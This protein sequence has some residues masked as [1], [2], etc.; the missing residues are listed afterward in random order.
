[1]GRGRGCP[2]RGRRCPMAQPSPS[3]HPLYLQIK[4]LVEKSLEDGEWR[5]GE[6]IPSETELASRYEVSQGTV[7]KAVDALAAA[8]L[9]VRRQGKGTFVATHAEEKTSTHRFLNIYDNDARDGPTTSR[10][11][12][13]RRG[14]ASAEAAR[15]L[16]IKAGDAVIVL[17]RVLEY[18]GTPVVFDEIT[19]PA[20]L[21]RGLTRARAEAHGSSMY[22]FFETEFGVRM[23]K[24]RERLR[25]VAAESEGARVL[26]VPVGQ[27]LLAVERVAYTYGERPVELRRG[28]VM[29]RRH[30]YYNELG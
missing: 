6:P 30:H 7:R 16:G 11:L 3:F 4:A 20:A 9:V 28:L 19:L 14:K 17:T 2:A 23:V 13:V 21:F 22:A 18:G 8:N 25:A 12:D 24:A 15:L 1:M 10:L 29:T 27:P 26:G 5:P